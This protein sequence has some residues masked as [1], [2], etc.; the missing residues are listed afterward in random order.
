MFRVAS[1]IGLVAIVLAAMLQ[2]DARL[3]AQANAASNI[4]AFIGDWTMDRG[5]STFPAAAPEWRK[6]KF[7]KT[8]MGFRHT[9][10]SMIGEVVQKITYTFQVDGKDYP[11]DVQMATN[12][13]SYK[14]VDANT[15]ERSGKQQGNVIETVTMTLSDGGKTLTYVQR[16]AANDNAVN[17]TQVFTKAAK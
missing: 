13:I 17:S 1:R 9:V 16:L 3:F 4:D 7:E 15:L 2:V 12:T 6:M 14:R 10:D 5:K 11:A 8:P